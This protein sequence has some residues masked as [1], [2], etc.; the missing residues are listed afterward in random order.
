[1]RRRQ[2]SDDPTRAGWAP[3]RVQVA[4]TTPR[5]LGHV[6]LPGGPANPP[7]LA[8]FLRELADRLDPPTPCPDDDEAAS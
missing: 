4:D 2:V 8:A 7:A 5:V 3:V 6:W 1:M